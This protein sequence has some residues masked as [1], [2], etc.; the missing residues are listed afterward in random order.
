VIDLS[1]SGNKVVCCALHWKIVVEKENIANGIYLLSGEDILD[2]TV[3]VR[4]LRQYVPGDDRHRLP[5]KSKRV[6]AEHLMPGLTTLQ[7]NVPRR[8]NSTVTIMGYRRTRTIQKFD[9]ILHSRLKCGSCG[10]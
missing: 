2:Y 9:P 8:P 5:F 6:I 3:H 1:S 4:L 10:L 7:D